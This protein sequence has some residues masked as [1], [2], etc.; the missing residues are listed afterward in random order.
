[1]AHIKTISSFSPSSGKHF[2]DDSLCSSDD[3][4]HFTVVLI[5]VKVKVKLSLCLTRH[6][7]MKTYWGVKV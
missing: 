1:V 5:F 2:T 7:A 6:Y 3:S 4:D